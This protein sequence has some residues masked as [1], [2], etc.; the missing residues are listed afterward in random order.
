MDNLLFLQYLQHTD[1]SLLAV[2][3]PPLLVKELLIY[4]IDYELMSLTFDLVYWLKCH[5]I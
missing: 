5:V 1:T 4:G 3:G 2:N